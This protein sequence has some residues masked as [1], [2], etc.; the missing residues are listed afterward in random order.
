MESSTRTGRPP[1]L[2]ANKQD[3]ELTE[4]EKRL[5]AQILK[6]RERQKRAYRRKKLKKL[7]TL[8]ELASKEG[9][10]SE[11]QCS[12]EEICLPG[13]GELLNLTPFG[14][15]LSFS[16]TPYIIDF[17]SFSTSSHLELEQGLSQ[18]DSDSQ[19]LLR[20]LTMFQGTFSLEAARAIGTTMSE[21]VLIKAMKTFLWNNFIYIDDADRFSMNPLVKK[22]FEEQCRKIFDTTWKTVWCQA[23]DC[24]YFYFREQLKQLTANHKVYLSGKDRYVA[25]RF[26]DRERENIRMCLEYAR[27]R[28]KLFLQE[29]LSNGGVVFRFGLGGEKR[30]QYFKESLGMCASC[31]ERSCSIS[32]LV[33]SSIAGFSWHTEQEAILLHY[34]GESY[35]DCMHWEEAEMCTR[36]SIELMNSLYSENQHFSMIPSLLLLSN[37]LY[38]T[39]R[40]EE[41]KQTITSVMEYIHKYNLYYSSYTANSLIVLVN[42]FLQQNDL[43]NARKTATDL[44][45]I[46]KSIEFDELPLFSETLGMF[47]LISHAE[48]Q[49]AQAEK[50]FRQALDSLKCWSSPH[51]WFDV[52][53]KHCMD[54]DLWL[55]ESLSRVLRAQDKHNEAEEYVERI[56]LVAQERHLCLKYVSNCSIMPYSAYKWD[57]RGPSCSPFLNDY[58]YSPLFLTDLDTLFEETTSLQS[59]KPSEVYHRIFVKH[60]Y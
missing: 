33:S 16:H 46:V 22:Y 2:F 14:R 26:I 44:L 31:L 41:A 39:E 47:G 52:P 32:S 29:F 20:L 9:Q 40:F 8:L 45:D 11:K 43:F 34:L 56:Q 3:S 48:S 13:K 35:A 50:E 55:M 59:M 38:E 17:H 24:V 25:M 27:K 30:V 1:S 28:G 49:L 54:L 5:K 4:E 7:H 53:M 57:I 58:S 37:I 12:N 60:V 19:I 51:L 21:T 36:L 42:L 15:N 23:E 10:L 18:L 6:R